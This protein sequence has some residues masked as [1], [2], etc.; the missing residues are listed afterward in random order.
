MTTYLSIDP[1]LLEEALAVGGHETKRA[2]VEEV[3][4]EYVERRKQREIM[5]L[6]GT[7]DYYD[8]SD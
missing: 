1:A 7:I 8:D 3:L 5:K 6:F 4:E 2:T